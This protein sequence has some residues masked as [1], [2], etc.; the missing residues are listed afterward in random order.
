MRFGELIAQAIDERVIGIK[1]IALA[2]ATTINQANAI[3]Q[4]NQ[5]VTVSSRTQHRTA[6]ARSLF[7]TQRAAT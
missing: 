7:A 2:T 5:L 3:R 4:S 6:M 1:K